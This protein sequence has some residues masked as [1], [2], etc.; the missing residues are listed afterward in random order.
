MFDQKHILILLGKDTHIV[1]VGDDG[2]TSEN[3]P[4]INIASICASEALIMVR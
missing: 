4:L 1:L 3:Y 2:F